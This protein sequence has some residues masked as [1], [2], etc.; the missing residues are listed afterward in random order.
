MKKNISTL[1]QSLSPPQLSNQINKLSLTA[2][3]VNKIKIN[4]L[5]QIKTKGLV[6]FTMSSK[7]SDWT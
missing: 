6:E 3:F 5:N 7:A 4:I 1:S 2:T